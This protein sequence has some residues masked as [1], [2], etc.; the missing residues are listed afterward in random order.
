MPTITAAGTTV[1]DAIAGSGYAEIDSGHVVVFE[2]PAELVAAV[3]G[4][5]F[6]D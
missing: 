3:S 2:R 5:L 6:A 4:F 1:H